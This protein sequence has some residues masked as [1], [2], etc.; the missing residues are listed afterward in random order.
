MIFPR[1]EEDTAME[2]CPLAG[3]TLRRTSNC[4]LFSWYCRSRGLP[5]PT[6]SASTA[7]PEPLE[8]SCRSAPRSLRS[9]PG[10][11]RPDA[12]GVGAAY[13]EAET[14]HCRAIPR[15]RVL[16]RPAIDRMRP[17]LYSAGESVRNSPSC[18]P[19]PHRFTYCNSH[20]TEG[21][22]TITKSAGVITLSNTVGVCGA[23]HKDSG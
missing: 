10:T 3:V 11:F 4:L 8:Q 16:R 1:R 6:G 5:A 13:V 2:G 21:Y 17:A 23:F 7:A 18:G 15:V 22:R 14:L 19:H 20:I 12:P 9:P